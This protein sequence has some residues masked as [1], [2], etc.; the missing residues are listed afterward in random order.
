LDANV[1][2][3]VGV[4]SK[5]HK[6]GYKVYKY[7]KKIGKQVYPIHPAIKELDGDIVYKSL[8]DVP[9]VVEVV[10]VVV[11][12]Q[13]TE[14]VVVECYELG[15]KKVWMQPGAESQKA[16]DFCKDNDIDVVYNSCIM[17]A[18]LD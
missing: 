12:P 15:I 8:K 17:L 13:V 18:P 9:A 14:K 1:Y 4:S 6:Y 11:S 16:I 7:L 2:A 10:D 5:P 3:V